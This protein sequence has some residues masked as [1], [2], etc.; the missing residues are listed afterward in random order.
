M[1]VKAEQMSNTKASL[2]W[3]DRPGKQNLVCHQVNEGY[4]TNKNSLFWN[5]IKS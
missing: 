5:V 2:S 3:W 1:A 4:L